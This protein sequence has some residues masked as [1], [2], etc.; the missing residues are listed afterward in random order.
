MITAIYMRV[1]TDLQSIKLQEDAISSYLQYRGL[2]NTQKYVDEDK[3]G[4]NTDREALNK[5]LEDCKQGKIERLV[6]W[7][8]DRLSRSLEDL[9]SLIKRLNEYNVEFV[10]V[11][12]NIDLGN[13]FGK[14]CMQILGVFSEFER[15]M[16]SVRTK[17]GMASIKASTGKHMGRKSSLRPEVRQHVLTMRAEGK[18]FKEIE[19]ETTLSYQTVRRIVIKNQLN[20]IRAGTL[21][22]K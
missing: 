12:E 21:N 14:A 16:I 5:L 9:L 1:S 10:S 4:K 7:K 22:A 6:V 20:A 11:T 17:A 18:T 19:K 2:T 3:S 8:T 15:S 13:P